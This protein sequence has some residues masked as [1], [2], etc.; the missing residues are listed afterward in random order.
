MNR[1]G[2]SEVLVVAAVA[3]A[4]A[5]PMPAHVA[6]LGTAFTYQGQLQQSGAPANGL[7]DFRFGVFGAVSGGTQLGGTQAL[8][9]VA[10]TNGVFTVQLDFGAVPFGGDLRWLEIAVRC[11]AGSGSY[12]TLLPR[13][14]ITPTPYALYAS[15]AGGVPWSAVTGVP[16]GLADGIDNDSGDVTAVTAGQGLTG[17]GNAG[18]V[19]LDVAFAVSGSSSTVARGDHGHTGTYLPVGGTVTC[20]GGQKVT[21]ISASTGDVLCATDAASGTAGHAMRCRDRAACA[22][23][24]VG[25]ALEPLATGVGV[26]RAIVMLQ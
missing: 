3:L 17:G 20:L 7:C 23:A 4:S 2:Y 1:S 22:G 15:N 25:K 8:D 13:Q 12:I 18:D 19:T 9:A 6:A 5:L 26:I 11:P 16:S 21:G 14:P 10:V 24:I